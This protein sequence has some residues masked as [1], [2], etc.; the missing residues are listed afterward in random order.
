MDLL[1]NEIAKPIPEYE[2]YYATTLGRIWSEK[3]H[4]W[5]KQSLRGDK[6][7]GSMYLS[8]TLSKDGIRKSYTVHRLIAET[9]I[10]NP[11]NFPQVNHKDENKLN[12]KIENLEWCDNQYNVT[13]GDRLL[14]SVATR[15]SNGHTIKVIMYDKETKEPIKI[16]NTANEAARFASGSEYTKG[17]HILQVCRGER[18]SAYGYFWKF[19]EED[20]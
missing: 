20:T 7:I 6:S 8:V 1:E 15:I 14:K 9:F 16:F 4:K 10:P 18:K 12:N 17:T 3:S 19:F 5:L 13:Y 2:E 11:N